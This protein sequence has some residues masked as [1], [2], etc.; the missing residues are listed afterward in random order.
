LN[1]KKHNC[2]ARPFT[3]GLMTIVAFAVLSL[4]AGQSTSAVAGD[5]EVLSTF[6]TNNVAIAGNFAYAAAGTQGIVIVDLENLSIAGVVATPTGTSGVDDVAI[7]GDLLFVMEGFSGSL[8]VMS[9]ANPAQPVVVSGPVAVDVGPFSGVSA[10]NGRVVVSGGTG[11]LSSRGYSPAGALTDPVLTIDL[12]T[13]QP[14]VL[15]SEDGATAFVSTDFA[16]TFDGQGFGITTVDVSGPSLSILDR[17]GVAGAGFSLGVD[18]PANFPAESALQ[19]DTLFFASGNGISVFDVSN[20]NSVQT[21]AVI[22][23][24]T[25]P[26]NVDVVNDTL[27]VVGNGPGTLT[28]IDIS[29]LSSPVVQTTALAAGSGPLGVAVSSSHLVIADEFLGVQVEVLLLRGDVNGD[30]QVNFL[31]ITPFI[32][33]LSSGDFLEAAD[34]DGNGEVNFLDITPFISLLAG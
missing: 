7:D 25:N 34:I 5:I 4:F 9:I 17:I 28:T 31:D 24:S 8:S 20:P 12:G 11:L 3:L 26:I 10:A 19:G 13:G 23:L 6:G 2:A 33:L 18:F 16:G 32:G 14:D 22:P 15:L 21:L 1:I 27:Y 30:G 29:D